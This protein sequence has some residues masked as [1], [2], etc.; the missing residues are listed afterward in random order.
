[1]VVLSRQGFA[2]RYRRCDLRRKRNWERGREAPR[3]EVLLPS[4]S[5]LY[6][7][8][9]GGGGAALDPSFKGGVRPG[10]GRSPPSPTH[11]GESLP[12]LGL[13]PYL[14]LLVHGP[15]GAGVLGPCRPR[16]TPYSPCA[17]PGQVDPP[18]GPPDPF[19]HSRYTAGNARN[20][21][22]EQNGT[23]HI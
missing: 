9:K 15:I 14:S 6:I 10:L 7:G 3:L 18:G 2:K 23:S 20:F 21:S 12:P 17:P 11:L 8:G 16:R 5:P 19:R 1:M 4:F 22:G 13:F